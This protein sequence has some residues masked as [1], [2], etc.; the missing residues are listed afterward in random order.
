MKKHLVWTCYF[1]IRFCD[2]V[3][4]QKQTVH[5][6]QVWAGYINQTRLN[7]KWS[8]WLDMHLRTKDDFVNNFST[9]ILRAGITYHPNDKIRLTAGYA[10]VSAYPG[11]NHG[12]VTRPEHR[13]WQQVYW[14]STNPRSRMVQYIRLEERYRRKI[15]NAN[16]LDE[17]YNFNFKLRYSTMLNIPLGAKPFAPKT[18][19]VSLNNEVHVNFGKEIVYNYFD[20]NRFLAG[21]AYHVSESNYLQFGYMN[22]FQQL[23]AGDRYRMIHAAR[24]YF[25]H[26]IDLRKK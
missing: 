26:N 2:E 9:S 7:D 18:L 21:F 8:T 23:A 15:K 11:D 25:Y 20:Q 14:Q 22:L 3:S 5:A 16:E 4:A 1:L 17:G 24:V 19:S 6:Q 13:P 12:G 10:Y